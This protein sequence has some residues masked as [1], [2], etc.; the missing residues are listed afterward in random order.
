MKKRNMYIL[1]D[2]ELEEYKL[3]HDKLQEDVYESLH[4]WIAQTMATYR[5]VFNSDD[6]LVDFIIFQL[7]SGAEE[8][9]D[10]SKD[11]KF[12]D[13]HIDFYVNEKY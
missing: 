1:N 8:I 5:D 3:D 11:K 4:S 9:E 6:E 12:V 13:G 2:S 10:S 7:K